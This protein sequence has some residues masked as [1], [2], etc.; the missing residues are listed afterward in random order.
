MSVQI[1]DLE[2]LDAV[3]DFALDHPHPEIGRFK[4]SM[5]AWGETWQEVTPTYLAA[6]DI[7][8]TAGMST[9]TPA[10]AL[11]AAFERHKSRLHWEQSYKKEDGLVP[12]AMLSGYGYAEII[13]QRGPF[14]SDRIRAG[15]A[16][17]GPHIVYPRHQHEAEEIYV[18]L[19]GA[20]EFKLG[21]G[22]ETRQ[23]AGDVV[24]VESNM[25]HGFRTTDQSLV[26]YY[27]WQAGDLRQ[28]SKFE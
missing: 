24:Y 15:I 4:A 8:D 16:I 26:V 13:G 27:L 7:L 21:S 11:V 18:V 3:R 19:A 2:L 1:K 14:I 12:D 23:S 25:P 9:E 28:Q 22:A 10:S 17:W 20:A 5:R 6:A